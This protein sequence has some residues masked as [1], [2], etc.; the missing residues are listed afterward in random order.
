MGDGAGRSSFSGRLM[1]HRGL[2]P[3]I[4]PF[5]MTS[6]HN[7]TPVTVIAGYLGAGKTTLINACLQTRGE[8]KIAVLVNDFGDINIDAALIE[9]Q[10]DTVLNLAGGCVCCSIGSDFMEAL[11]ELAALPHKFDHVLVESS[12][13]ALPLPIAQ[14]IALS[15]SFEVAAIFVLADQESIQGLLKDAYVGDLVRQQL[16]QADC[17][18]LTKS[19][20]VAKGARSPSTG[21]GLTPEPS[22]QLP[23][24]DF[25][26]PVLTLPRSAYSCEWLLGTEARELKA[27]Q[28]FKSASMPRGADE[29]SH[30]LRQADGDVRYKRLSESTSASQANAELFESLAIELDA[31]LDLPRVEATLLKMASGPVPMIL[32]AK[33]FVRDRSRPLQWQLLQMVGRRLTLTSMSTPSGLAQDSGLVLILIGLRREMLARQSELNDFL[34]VLQE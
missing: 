24:L 31:P 27:A 10:T 6:A 9:S 30:W 17:I 11:F 22:S 14:S 23:E 7:Q 15:Q 28:S 12:G 3:R 19:D 26:G 21:P 13:V 33:G 20:L 1:R 32:R 29:R 4:A 18:L 25:S 5:A 34:A 8:R 16:Q 2:L